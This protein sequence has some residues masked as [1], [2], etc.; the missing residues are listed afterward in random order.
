MLLK[1]F[2]SNHTYNFIAFP[3][4]GVLFWLKDLILPTKFPLSHAEKNFLLFAPVYRWLENSVFI[5]NVVSLALVQVMAIV[6]L[7]IN[8]RYNLLR[9]RTMIHAT[10]FVILTGGLAGIHALHPVYFSA[11]CL[12][13]AMYRLFNAYDQPKPYSPAFDAGFFLGM[14]F[15]FYYSLIVIFPAMIVG[16]GL[17][18]RD[19]NWRIFVVLLIGFMLPPVFGASYAFYTDQLPEL[20]KSVESG[21]FSPQ[22]HFTANIPLQVYLGY[23]ILL[24]FAGSIKLIRE[25]G[26][27]KVSTRKFFMVFFLIFISSV[28]AII[29]IPAVSHAFLLIVLIPVNFLIANFFMF[30]KNRFWS[31]FLFVMLILIA[32]IVQIV[33]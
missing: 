22:N 14:S 3:L 32:A 16:I 24:I 30:L 13:I 21:I 29:F 19:K 2:K 9:V 18:S 8:N 28:A 15:L 17:L 1:K 31:E 12:L 10:L 7:L 6:L 27:K 20:V 11:V 26:T 25:Y 4:L 5:Q 23:L 33:S